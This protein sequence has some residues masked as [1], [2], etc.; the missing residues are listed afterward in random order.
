M[1]DHNVPVYGTF[2]VLGSSCLKALKT[3][4]F[5]KKDLPW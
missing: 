5:T 1:K 3:G 4:N 2:L